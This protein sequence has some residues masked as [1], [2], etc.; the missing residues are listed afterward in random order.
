[1]ATITS[2]FRLQ[3]LSY[4]DIL[5]ISIAPTLTVGDPTESGTITTTATTDQEIIDRAHT[6][7]TFV[8]V[9]NTG[10]AATDGN[11]LVTDDDGTP[12]NISLLK[13]GEFLFIPLK[14][15]VGMRL[16]YDTAVTSVEW[17]YWT[18]P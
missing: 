6:K 12:N 2:T 4:T 16:K 18:R 13:P 15:G 11:I 7:D 1:M 14:S 5:N 8:F 17:H 9:R 10:T 3:S